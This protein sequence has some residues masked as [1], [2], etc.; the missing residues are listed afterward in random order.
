MINITIQEPWFG[1]ILSF[2]K[3]VE[4]R[5]CNEKYAKIQ[6]GD[7]I[8]VNKVVMFK[9]SHVSR[10]DSFKTMLTEEGLENVLP[11]IQ[12][13]QEGCDVYHKFYS[14]EDEQKYGVVALHVQLM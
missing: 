11:G 8:C 13:I 6:T 1:H 14:R 12:S 2:Q 7:I 9:V 3:T 4:G 5:L 10:Y